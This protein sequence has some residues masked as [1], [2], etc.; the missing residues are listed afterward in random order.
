[1]SKKP[2][3]IGAR[4]RQ[5][6]R[7]KGWTLQ[8]ASR[9]CDVSAV[10]LGK[11]ER[12]EASPTIQTLWKL[13]TGFRVPLTTLIEPEPRAIDLATPDK[14]NAI[15]EEAGAMMACPLFAYD[16]IQNYEMFWIRFA[17]GCRHA[18]PA[19][20]QRVVE[21]VSVIAGTLQIELPERTVIVHPGEAA[22]FSADV[23][24]TYENIG[25]TDCEVY[26]QIFY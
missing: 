24:H 15:E 2:D 10:M 18:S 14:T 8:T 19:H 17:P 25:D 16:P 13:A 7:S 3:F 6:R 26:D 20:D 11:I 5:I 21:L 9:Q 22:R 12:G 23:E 4:V 1:M